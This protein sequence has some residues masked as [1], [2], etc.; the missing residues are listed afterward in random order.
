MVIKKLNHIFNLLSISIKHR[1]QYFYISITKSNKIGLQYLYK[2]NYINF[3]KIYKN[4][5]IIY[6]NYYHFNKFKY[7]FKFFKSK[8]CVNISNFYLNK[9]NY[10]YL[11][12]ISVKNNSYLINK[13]DAMK[14]ACN[15]KLLAL[16]F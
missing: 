11:L 6:I 13:Y 8:Q 4:K 2:Y 16:L 3:F 10:N 9:L 14:C 15:G 12:S 7:I 5:I 1:K